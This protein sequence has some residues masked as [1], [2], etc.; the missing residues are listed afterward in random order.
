MDGLLIVDKPA[1]PTSHDVVARVRRVLRERRVGHTGTLDPRASG[2]LPLVVG[3]AT[4]LARF[5]S[6]G[7]KCYEAVLELG[8]A[9][10]T[11][12]AEGVPIADGRMVAMPTR[13]AIDEALEG[14]RGTFLQRPPAF[15]A[16]KVQGRRSYALARG[17]RPIDR[18]AAVPV[19]AYGIDVLGLD[20]TDLALRVECS[21]GFYVRA[22]AHDLGVRL[23]TGAHLKALRRTGSA[24]FALADAVALD[25]VE[26]DPEAA[27][28]AMVPLVDI[29]RGLSAVVLTDAGRR[30]ARQ[31][32]EIGPG[33]IMSGS[34]TDVGAVRLIDVRG[35]L[36]GVGEPGRSAGLLHP[37]VVLV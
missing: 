29:L 33:D 15:S 27:R 13:T 14:F 34:L 23:G 4:R 7:V 11:Y 24:G 19:T 20:G 12:D 18:P 3:R 17:R 10:D 30:R 36:V 26:R 21:A 6:S 8:V 1:G 22:L 5:L 16:K 31:G 2:V 37:S 32:L 9:T 28:T 25:A 35:E